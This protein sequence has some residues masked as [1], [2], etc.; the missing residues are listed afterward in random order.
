MK[1]MK[2]LACM[3]A[4]NAACAENTNRLPGLIYWPEGDAI[5][6]RNGTVWDN[7]PLY[8]NGRQAFVW[9]GELP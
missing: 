3:L 5:V 2:T 6:V 4:V 8:C 1:T 9:A 7:R